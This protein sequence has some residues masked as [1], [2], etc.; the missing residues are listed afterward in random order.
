MDKEQCFQSVNILLN[1]LNS[2][3]VVL[4]LDFDDVTITNDLLML[5]SSTL[6]MDYTFNFSPVIEI[7]VVKALHRLAH[8]VGFD[9]ILVSFIKVTL[10]STLPSITNLFNTLLTTGVYHLI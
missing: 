7:Y 2:Y 5:K 1:E 3:F 9:G 8:G 10:V 6:A 4:S